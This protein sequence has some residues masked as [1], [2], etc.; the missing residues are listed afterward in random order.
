MIV[1]VTIRANF[2]A[3]KAKLASAEEKR[4]EALILMYGNVLIE[5]QKK[6]NILLSRAGNRIPY[7]DSTSL[8]QNFIFVLI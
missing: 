7:T 8:S 2:S 6:K 5:Q 4:K 1:L 3:T